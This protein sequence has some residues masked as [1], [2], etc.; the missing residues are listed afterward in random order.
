MLLQRE[1]RDLRV[2]I[3]NAGKR[4]R[5]RVASHERAAGWR[6]YGGIEVRYTLDLE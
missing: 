2:R 5:L 1:R 6:I 3:R 4:V